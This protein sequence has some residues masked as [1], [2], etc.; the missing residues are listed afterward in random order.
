MGRGGEIRDWSDQKWG[1]EG[2]QGV[3]EGVWWSKMRRGGEVGFGEGLGLA[4]RFFYI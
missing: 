2:R 3:G 1:G 4:G